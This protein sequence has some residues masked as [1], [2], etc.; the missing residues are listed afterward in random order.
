MTLDNYDLQKEIGET[1]R[2]LSIKYG[3]RTTG[4]RTKRTALKKRK[5]V[6]QA[7][8]GSRRAAIRQLLTKFK[9][10][11]EETDLATFPHQL[12]KGHDDDNRVQWHC[13]RKS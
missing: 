8:H 12:M 3:G 9:G 11:P 4:G 1:N 13:F 6:D 7:Y 2:L 5:I 10:E